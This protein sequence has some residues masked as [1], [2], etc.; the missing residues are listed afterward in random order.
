MAFRRLAD[1]AGV[2]ADDM[3]NVGNMTA[4][5][6]E[7]AMSRLFGG[8]TASATDTIDAPVTHPVLAQKNQDRA[9]MHERD[10][11]S[12][13]DGLGMI[14]CVICA[15][16]IF[17]EATSN[18]AMGHFMGIYY[19]QFG[20]LHP[21]QMFRY[22]TSFWN[23][24]VRAEFPHVPVVTQSAVTHHFE[25][26]MQT[27]NVEQRLHAQLDR[28]ER[29]QDVLETNGLFVE[30]L[31]DGGGDEPEVET[32]SN[33]DAA[34]LRELENKVMAIQKFMDRDRDDD[35]A[36]ASRAVARS[37]LSVETQG[38]MCL[39]LGEMTS[40]IGRIANRKQLGRKRKRVQVSVAEGH[41]FDK[42]CAR[43][44][45]TAKVLLDWKK[46]NETVDGNKRGLPEYCTRKRA[47][48]ENHIDI[49]TG[50]KATGEMSR[51]DATPDTAAAGEIAGRFVGY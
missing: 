22:M 7:T 27:Q 51:E 24:D 48:H 14:E 30:A 31:D 11:F 44:A 6:H 34:F 3:S 16:G 41:L 1:I 39:M 13:P 18:S 36:G 4:A 15:Y 21:P 45:Q 35:V 17:N 49:Y 40:H 10:G 9:V 25:N 28:I 46:Y 12:E 47:K 38:K 20:R 43:A 37:G 33:E 42:Y 2:D 32:L 26:C 23:Y 19:S 29:V 8:G 5:R 50:K